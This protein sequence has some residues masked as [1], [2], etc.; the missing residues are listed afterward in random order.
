MASA[1]GGQTAARAWPQGR[2]RSRRSLRNI[3]NSCVVRARMSERTHTRWRRVEIPHTWSRCIGQQ[4][5]T[6][7]GVAQSSTHAYRPKCAG[8]DHRAAEERLVT[9][10]RAS[11]AK[12]G[13]I[14]C[15]HARGKMGGAAVDAPARWEVDTAVDTIEQ[16][17]TEL[18]TS[19]SSRRSLP[20]TR[21]QLSGRGRHG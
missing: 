14:G 13:P 12:F 17:V 1:S 16:G 19:K 21:S 6:T 11:L 9:G 15:L 20:S 7:C 3:L 18:H 4:A 2:R 10:L 8:Y 5:Q